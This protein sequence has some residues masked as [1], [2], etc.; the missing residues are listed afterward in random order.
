M[1]ITWYGHSCFRITERGHTSVLTDPCHPTVDLAQLKLK[2]DLIT[3]SHQDTARQATQV[4]DHRYVIAGPGEYEVGELFITG[5]PLHLHDAE[6]D[7]LL[8]NVAYHLEYPSNLNVLHLGVLRA[9]PDQSIIEE[10]G[11]VNA[12]LLPVGGGTLAS[13]ELADLISMIEPS[14]VVPMHPLG[15]TRSDF[16]AG[17]DGFLKAMGVSNVETQD[18]LRIT[19]SNLPEQIQVVLLEANVESG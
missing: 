2:A 19:S 7:T 14:Y 10:L 18:S 13:D 1:D 6:S 4:K 3:F 12:L 9:L 15:V 5:I 16:Q 8:D 17:T 11:V